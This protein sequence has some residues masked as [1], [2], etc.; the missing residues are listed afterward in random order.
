M[1]KR[2]PR[3]F[4]KTGDIVGKREVFIITHRE[5]GKTTAVIWTESMDRWG[6]VSITTWRRW[7]KN[8]AVIKHA[9]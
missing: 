5:T 7:A 1:G 8:Q 4:P 2:D 6:T 9:D 3:V